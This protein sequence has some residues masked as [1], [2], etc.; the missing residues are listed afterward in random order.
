MPSSSERWQEVISGPEARDLYRAGRAGDAVRLVMKSCYEEAAAVGPSEAAGL[1]TALVHRLLAEAHVPSQRKASHRGVEVDVAVPGLR[2]L[3]ADPSGVLLVCIPGTSDPGMI[4]RIVGS[5]RRIQP[6][7]GNVWAVL[8]GPAEAP[9][10]SF[11]AG[12]G[13]GTLAG[14][15]DAVRGFAG[16]GGPSL[17]G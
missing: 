3:D 11:A 13:G 8:P 4:S 15:L 7:P 5:Y 10:R 9:C 14:F 6:V 12:P 17:A 16:S 1:V 2:G